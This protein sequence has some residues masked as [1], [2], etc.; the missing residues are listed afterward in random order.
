[1]FLNKFFFITTFQ[2]F[3]IIICGIYAQSPSEVWISPKFDLNTPGWDTIRF[4]SIQKGIYAVAEQGIVNIDTGTYYENLLINRNINLLGKGSE[5]SIVNACGLDYAVFIDQVSGGSLSDLSFTNASKSGIYLYSS[6][7]INI[8][9][10]TCYGNAERGIIIGECNN[11]IINNNTIYDNTSCG[12]DLSDSYNNLIKN[13]NISSSWP[14]FLR[15]SWENRI[16]NNEFWGTTSTV[17][18]YE[19]SNN[20]IIIN[21]TI[22]G[23][24]ACS[25]IRSIHSRN[26]SYVNN[27]L[28]GNTYGNTYAAGINLCYSQNCIILNN[29]I[30]EFFQRGIRLYHTDSTIILGNK[31]FDPIIPRDPQ[32]NKGGILVFG[33]SC[34]NLIKGNTILDT[35]DGISFHHNSNDNQIV[36]NLI[37]GASTGIIIHTSDSNTI[38]KNNLEDNKVHGFDDGNNEWS[39]NGTGNYWSDYNTSDEDCINQSMNEYQIPPNG[40]DYYPSETSFNIEPVDTPELD[41]ISVINFSPDITYINND[42]IWENQYKKISVLC[43]NAGWTLIINNSTVNFL[44]ESASGAGIIVDGGTLLINNSTILFNGKEFT[45]EQGA[46]FEIR[47]SKIYNAGNWGGGG[48]ISNFAENVVFEDN[49]IFDI[50]G[51]TFESNSKLTNNHFINIC[52]GINIHGNN[53][54]VNN[55]TFQNAINSG[56]NM[57]GCSNNDIY[58]NTFINC[59]DK[60][61]TV[62]Y[63]SVD[64]NIYRNNFISNYNSVYSDGNDAFNNWAMNEQGN[65]YSDY[66][67]RYPAAKENELIND[68]WDIPYQMW[69]DNIDEYPLMTCI[70]N[71]TV[72]AVPNKPV[73]TDPSINN[74]INNNPIFKWMSSENAESY[75]IQISEDSTFNTPIV[76]QGNVYDTSFCHLLEMNKKYYWRVISLNDGGYSNWSEVRNF[77]LCESIERIDSVSISQGESYNGHTEEGTYVENLKTVLGCDSIITT[78]LIITE[79]EEILTV[80]MNQTMVHLYP[81]PST[82]IITV[83][84]E[85]ITDEIRITIFTIDGELIFSKLFT[86]S[87]KKLSEIIDLQNHPNGIYFVKF[88]IGQESKT[89]KIVIN[90]M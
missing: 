59:W 67:D 69:G 82:G 61:I 14:L 73:L 43:V 7:S 77:A 83:S 52:E 11:L 44:P 51:I 68:H 33:E 89:D 39:F 34:H 20:N 18:L 4:D 76:N 81:N 6:D 25:L 8:Q 79:P 41:T 63:Q 17:S 57:L 16:E 71:D 27:I 55:N 24:E 86:D 12:L 50:W 78:V 19:A 26:N 2:L 9:N 22:Y 3:N 36:N 84:L 31:I 54:I 74:S 15:H 56:I 62:I 13:N 66:L 40:K 37:K 32:Y 60:A 42:E 65:F 87:D 70:F 28:K 45:V 49:L 1:M 75:R 64:N 48:G 38:Y 90:K 47:N 23:H 85:N 58:D 10:N 53:S 30:S 5:S 21:N 88:S 46:R 80:Q 29:E 35:P 72:I